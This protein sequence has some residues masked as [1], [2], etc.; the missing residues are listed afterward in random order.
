MAGKAGRSGRKS[1][2]KE[3]QLR[4]L[5]DLSIPVL[6]HAL[7]SNK[8]ILYMKKIDIALALVQKMTPQKME[9]DGFGDRYT[10][11]GSEKV[12]PER[13]SRLVTLVRERAGEVK[14]A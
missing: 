12:N 7:K 4:A 5:W 14:P 9:G 6:K 2:D 11:I 1:W 3:I 10:F 13:M 8:K